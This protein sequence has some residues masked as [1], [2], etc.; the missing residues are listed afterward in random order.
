MIDGPLCLGVA[1]VLVL[2]DLWAWRGRRRELRAYHAWWVAYE[3]EAA[4]RHQTFMT[5]MQQARDSA[6]HR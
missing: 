5:A 1:V 6:S 4:R 2:L 3:I